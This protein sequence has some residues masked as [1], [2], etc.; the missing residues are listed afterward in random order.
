MDHCRSVARALLTP[1][2]PSTSLDGPDPPQDRPAFRRHPS[3]AT[4]AFA[5]PIPPLR[6]DVRTTRSARMDVDDR[7]LM[8]RINELAL[9]E[10][11]L[12]SRASQ[13]GGL[14]AAEQERLHQ[15][16]LAL[17]QSYD[18]LN[19]RRARRSAGLNPDEAHV[20][21]IDIVENYEQ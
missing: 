11:Q 3:R 6:Q 15:I 21:P 14:D 8:T 2:G 19:Q 12:W 4:E 5:S 13:E 9:E 18:L 20:R 16:Q 10:E 17:D 1:S 7:D